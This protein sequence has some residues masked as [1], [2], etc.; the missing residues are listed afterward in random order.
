MC[1]LAGIFSPRSSAPPRPEELR[2][3]AAALR[4]RGPD[5]W[6]TF[7]DHRCGLAHARLALL[8][9]A[10][11]DQ[12]LSGEDARVWVA[13]NGEIYNHDDLRRQ[14]LRAGHHFATGSDTEVIVHAYE[15]WGPDAW[16]RLQG[17]FAVALYDA[18]VPGDERLVLARDRLGICPLHTAC[19]PAG[20]LVFASEIKALF[21]MGRVQPR[22]DPRGLA[23]AW[24]LWSTPA[25]ATV[26][27]SVEQL[28]PG[29]TLTID[30]EARIDRARF[31]SARASRTGPA[32]TDDAAR[33][34]AHRL[35]SAVETRL[36]ADVPVGVY[37]SGGLD[38]SVIAALA[39]RAGSAPIETFSIRFDDARYDEGPAQHRV[40]T[41]LGTR[42]HELTA[43]PADIAGAL[44][45]AVFAAESPL[46]RLG[47]VPM[48]LLSRLVR[49]TGF[50]AVLTGEGADELFTGYDLFKEA[51][52]RR[53]WSRSPESPARPA[54]LARVHAYVAADPSQAAMWRDYFRV[55][56]DA[57]ADPLASHRPRW[58]TGL[59]TTRFLHPDI[60]AGGLPASL[61][62]LVL[63]AA[64]VD[65][66][67]DLLD[68]AAAIERA[69]F[70]SSYL[71]AAQGDRVTL[72]S[73]VEARYP[74]LDERVVDLALSLAPRHRLCGLTDKV[75]LRRL[76]AAFLPPD[77]RTRRKFPFRAPIAST[78]FGPSAPD[79]VRERLDARAVR[80]A[81]LLDPGP[82]AA[83]AARAF[84]PS[85]LSEREEMAAT[86]ALTT[87]VLH[88]RLI[89]DAGWIDQR[90]R[91]LERTPPSVAVDRRSAQTAHRPV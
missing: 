89:A 25:P 14:L 4:H 65:P 82:A 19:A 77:V 83:L 54:L 90:L 12:P 15:Q 18:R 74:F 35:T 71:L 91:T 39:Q 2:R 79:W 63:A 23:A 52:V 64:N 70:L 76:A 58:A 84:A 6:G 53:F 34:L 46:S 40:A 80:D 33:E 21:A 75:V 86:A 9:L 88:A 87:Q 44:E 26:F 28:P 48:L 30:A 32:S 57:L 56:L 11:G 1:G 78:L 51:K 20:G 41:L 7:I 55:G 36:R 66:A 42:H 22:I 50:K 59:W 24:A 10:A 17:Q 27:E 38:S 62:P 45:D 49:R 29:S 37:V 81:G 60:R 31:W 16:P 61:D 3:A 43:S 8:D 47:P 13:F 69:A 68:R 5:A 73:A 72:A 85:R 67:G